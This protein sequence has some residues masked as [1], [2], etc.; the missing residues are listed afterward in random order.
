MSLGLTDLLK[1]GYKHLSG[2]NDVVLQNIDA[3]RNLSKIT[4]SSFGPNGMNKMIVNHLEKLFVTNDAA[5]ITKELDVVHPAAKLIVLASQMQEQ[6]IGDGTNYV[7]VLAGELLSN[8]ESLLQKGLHVND[9]IQGYSMAGKKAQEILESLVVM[10]ISDVSKKEEVAKALKSVLAAKQIGYEEMLAPIVGKAC[11][12]ILP[13]NH[14]NFN[15]DSVRVAKILG[16]GVL[17]T[18]A[19]RGHVL[20]RDTEGT[21]KSVKGAKL[22]VFAAG[23]DVS[24]P[25]SKDSVLIK[26]PE[27]LKNYQRSEEK[28]IEENIKQIAESGVNVIVSGGAIGEMALHFFER[29]GMMVIKCLSKFELRRICDAVKATPL[30]RI[31][32][33][34]PEEIGH[35]D[36]IAVEEIGSTRV[37]IFKQDKEGSGIS[38]IVVR[39]STQNMLDDFE[40]AINDGVNVFKATAKDGR[41]LAGAAA[42]EIELARTLQAYGEET[43]GLVQYAIKKFGEAFEIVPRTLAENAGLKANDVLSSFYASHQKGNKNFGLDIEEG[44]LK[45]ATSLGI[46]DLL[47]TKANAIRLATDAAITVLKVDQIIMAKMAGGPK[48]RAPGPRDDE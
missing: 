25:E 24:K 4:R 15:V 23:F 9:I 42:S 43:P 1:D 14:K 38:T 46:Y 7:V 33:P 26:T 30:V 19:M 29:Y 2:L 41:F 21:V 22:A 34:T 27:D 47:A 8:A 5:T 10:T 18:Q 6:E 12:D 48:A 45:D 36:S 44:D 39:A 13:S 17:D 16:G 37:I 11:I 40:R 31:G 3:A 20:V 35:C 32:K 28:A